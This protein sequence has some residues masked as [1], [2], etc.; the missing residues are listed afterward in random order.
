[1]RPLLVLP[2]LLA[3]PPA[4]AG[5][6]RAGAAAVVITPPLGTP[7]AGYYSPRGA[8]GVHDDLNA[9]AIVLEKDGARAAL[10]ALDLISTTRDLVADAR[11]RIEATTKVPGDAVMISATHTHTGP[12]LPGRGRR[13]GALGGDSD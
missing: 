13:E 8:E 1:M 10:V 5:E 2:F 3:I 6:L 12:V 4:R 9:K 11:Q 7:M